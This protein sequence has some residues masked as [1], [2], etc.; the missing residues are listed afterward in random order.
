ME[1]NI[2][3]T[4]ILTQPEALEHALDRFEAGKLEPVRRA[5]QEGQFDRVILT[6]MGA[7]LFASYPVWLALAQGGY[8][9]S[10]VETGELVH[11]ARQLI[12]PHSLVWIFSQS[13]R[14]AEIVALLELLREV[15]PDGLLATVNDLESPL[16]LAAAQPGGSNVLL[17]IEAA[18]ETSVSTRT[19][20]NSLALGQL[21]AKFLCGEALEAHLADLH[22]TAQAMR[23][24]LAEWE[25][26]MLA[27]GQA[28]G[29]PGGVPPRHI[30]FLG[31]GS[32]LATAACGALILGEAA[33]APAFSMSAGEFRHGPLELCGPD[34]TAVLFAGPPETR[35]LNRR[36]LADLASYGAKA[37][38]VDDNASP[39]K[40]EGAGAE[41]G[42]ALLP[43]PQ[44]RG[45]GLPLAE[46]L[47][48]QMLALH[49]CVQNG[50]V[51]GKMKF[52]GKVTL[53]E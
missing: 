5:L 24:Y 19:Y 9:A 25:K 45:L 52:I 21:A 36:L 38:W 41:K 18:P 16:A 7:S 4:D 28:V 37:V 53:K 17:P 47:P 15:K 39:W 2:Y 48:V 49:L 14:S 42:T 11:F 50:I 29:G 27:A 26:H 12:T 46:M 32:S 30:V 34:L 10:W 20:L 51:P 22:K 1:S 6:G 43:M 3:L 23:G 35:P 8:P 33:K 40:G 13:G 31:R 44:T